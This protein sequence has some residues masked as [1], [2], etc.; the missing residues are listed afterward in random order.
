MNMCITL[1]AYALRILYTE[2]RGG[3]EYGNWRVG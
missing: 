1:H 2:Y 3:I